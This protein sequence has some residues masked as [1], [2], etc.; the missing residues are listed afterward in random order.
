MGRIVERWK[1]MVHIWMGPRRCA[2]ESDM[3]DFDPGTRLAASGACTVEVGGCSSGTGVRT[4]SS[5]VAA[6]PVSS[7]K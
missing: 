1:P 2:I 4:S 6:L 3:G 5:N 7:P